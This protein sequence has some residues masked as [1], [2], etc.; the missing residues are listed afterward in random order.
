[1]G[2]VPFYMSRV[3]PWWSPPVPGISS[4]CETNVR[5]YVH[6]RGRDPGVWFF[7]LEAANSLAVRIARGAGISPIFGP[8]CDWSGRETP[9]PMKAAGSGREKLVPVARFAAKVGPPAG[10]R[11]P[12]PS[13]ADRSGPP[14]DARTLS[15]RAVYPVLLSR[16]GELL[17]GRVHHAPYPVRVA[18]L[19]SLDETLLSAAGISPAGGPATPPSVTGVDVE[20][21]PLDPV[22][23]AF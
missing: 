3:R 13:T 4:F 1:M 2:L 9:S 6:F 11:D 14:W 17:A 12:R 23:Q 21:F 8:R 7:S 19:E 5:T 20:I 18:R 22:G 15:H 10:A 16:T